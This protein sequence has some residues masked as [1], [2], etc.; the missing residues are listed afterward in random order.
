MSYL[1][2]NFVLLYLFNFSFN[3][4]RLLFCEKREQRHFVKKQTE[5]HE[6]I[7]IQILLGHISNP[8]LQENR[9]RCHSATAM[10]SRI[11]VRSVICRASVIPVRLANGWRGAVRY[12]KVVQPLIARCHYTVFVCDFSISFGL[13]VCHGSTAIRPSARI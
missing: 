6:S 12:A 10:M 1:V 13:D 4:M 9:A 3:G 7:G 11:C 5:K 2:N 8:G